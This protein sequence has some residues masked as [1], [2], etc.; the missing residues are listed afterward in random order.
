MLAKVTNIT[1]TT[2]TANSLLVGSKAQLATTEVVT[3]GTTS[4]VRSIPKDQKTLQAELDAFR[5]KMKQPSTAT[6][7]PL[8]PPLPFVIENISLADI[9][10]SDVIFVTSADKILPGQPIT[11]TKILVESAPAEKR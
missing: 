9:H 4:F 2:I 10:T 1:G 8:L 7:T 6:S 3:T 5:E 11:A